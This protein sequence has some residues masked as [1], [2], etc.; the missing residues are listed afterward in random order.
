V[1][2]NIKT[3]KKILESILKDVSEHDARAFLGRLILE[4]EYL[5]KEEEKKEKA[6]LKGLFSDALSI[7]KRR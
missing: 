5:I 3:E 4:Y 7:E 1:N 6:V 2:R